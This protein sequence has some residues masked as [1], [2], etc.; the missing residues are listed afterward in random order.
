MFPDSVRSLEKLESL[1]LSL[2]VLSNIDN[3]LFEDTR[4]NLE[5]GFKFDDV[6]TAE[7]IGS[8]N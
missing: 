1:G 2:N 7:D 6:F 8:Y 3:R 5:Q 4:V